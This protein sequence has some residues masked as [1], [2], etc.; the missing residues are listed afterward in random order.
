MSLTS[1]ASLSTILISFLLGIYIIYK[2]PRNKIN[3]VFGTFTLCISSWVLVNFLADISS[4]SNQA[5]FWAR[6]TLAPAS[7]MPLLLLYFSTIFP[8]QLESKS[9]LFWL[10]AS[11]PTLVIL[12]L[13]LTKLN[14]ESVTIT[15]SGQDTVVGSLYYAFLLYFLIYILITLFNL[16][17]SYLK[18]S[19]LYKQQIIYLF[20]GLG[21]S[22]SLAL[23]L[24]VA[25]PLAGFSSLVSL[26]PLSSLILILSVSYAIVRHRLLDIEVI[27]RRS[28]VYSILLG[29]MIGLY[30]VL[31]FG[32]NR[33]K[34]V[35]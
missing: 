23:L 24:S 11:L 17:R 4:T 29:S 16:S 34:S 30:S 6:L 15:P 32:L 13:T 10:A 31:I 20:I 25:L 1:I 18:F 21:I 27:I 8:K 2:N 35:V 19:G 12:A 9:K 3:L 33:R 22:I 26:S 28:L 14:I 7:L 5:L